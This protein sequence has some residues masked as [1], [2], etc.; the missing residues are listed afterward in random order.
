MVY[1]QYKVTLVFAGSLPQRSFTVWARD[2][3]N[4]VD[5][6]KYD[7]MS[8]GYKVALLTGFDVEAL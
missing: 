4:A 1:N 7:A 5:V 3:A 6:A 2:A 8:L